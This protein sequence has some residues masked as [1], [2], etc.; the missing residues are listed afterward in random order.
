MQ[1]WAVVYV[2]GML[3][4]NA[5]GILITATFLSGNEIIIF[6]LCMAILSRLFKSDRHTILI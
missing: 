3:G 1:H 5:A 4:V 6:V 2:G